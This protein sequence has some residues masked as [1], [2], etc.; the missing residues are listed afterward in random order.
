MRISDWSSDVCSSDLLM[1]LIDT[2]SALAFSRSTRSLYCGASSTPLGR[3]AL[4]TGFCAAM[5]SNWLRAASKAACPRPAWSF[6]SKSKPVA[7]SE[8]HTSEL[9]SLMR[10][11]YAVFCLK[12]KHNTLRHHELL[13]IYHA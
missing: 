8:E 9:Q 7:R 6:S 2:P 4:R 5:P 13:A 1:S 12:Q 3:T 10:S 11:S